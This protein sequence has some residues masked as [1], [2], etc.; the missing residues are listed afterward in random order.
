MGGAIEKLSGMGYTKE[1]AQAFIQAHMDT[2]EDIYKAC[3]QYDFTTTDLDE[4]LD[5]YSLSD[6]QGYMDYKGYDIDLLDLSTEDYLIK[7]G[8]DIQAIQE[9]MMAQMSNPAE[10][11]ALSQQF[12]LTFD[13]MD[14]LFEQFNYA[15][16]ENYFVDNQINDDFESFFSSEFMSM[17]MAGMDMTTTTAD[18]IV[19]ATTE[20]L[21]TDLLI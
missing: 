3:E 11:L 12:G 18:V 5:E 15:D 16:I 21:P 7:Q 9:Q 8:F 10:F 2:P 19:V 1:D 14:D 20:V 4:L 13:M 6:I 17:D